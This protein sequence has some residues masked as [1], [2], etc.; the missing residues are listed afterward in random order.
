M[1]K[2][3]IDSDRR[4]NFLEPSW[5]RLSKRRVAN[6]R[7]VKKGGSW[8]IDNRGSGIVAAVGAAPVALPSD[9]STEQFGEARAVEA[10]FLDPDLDMGIIFDVPP[11][12]VGFPPIPDVR[13]TK[14][15]RGPGDQRTSTTFSRS[16]ISVMSTDGS[17]SLPALPGLA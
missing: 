7:T 11:S 5:T 9:E 1:V 3:T 2:C 10:F 4:S 6:R 8:T 16:F 14:D 15:Q 13:S 17:F 12:S